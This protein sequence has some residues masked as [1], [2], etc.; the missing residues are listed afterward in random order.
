MDEADK[1]ALFINTVLV[2]YA[3]GALD[4]LERR[5]IRS[6]IERAEITREQIEQ[7]T[8]GIRAG[9]LAFEPI[10][11]PQRRDEA[12]MLMVGVA[13]SD[14][15]LAKGEQRALIEWAKA[16]GLAP[17]ALQRKFREYWATDVL[18]EVFTRDP[19]ASGSP[20]SPSADS[21]PVPT[22]LVSD[23]FE[24]IEAF[25]SVTSGFAFEI[26]GL[27]EIS[28]VQS[29][30]RLAIFHTAEERV[31][32]LEMFRKLRF[33]FPG[34]SIIAVLTRH[35]AFQVSYLLEAKVFHCMVEPIYPGELHRIALAA[36]QEG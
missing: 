6:L 30:P 29:E 10:E 33:R 31:A 15:K 11:D 19:D 16:V 24:R 5:F 26:W 7:W 1:K 21:A 17:E 23:N 22:L 12:L 35:Q 34:A 32:S 18:A 13:S 20:L 27:E 9:E 36:E 25:K 28:R 3:D 8:T 14:E 4:P 2:A